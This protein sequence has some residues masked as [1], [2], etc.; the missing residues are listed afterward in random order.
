MKVIMQILLSMKSAIKN[1]NFYNE[2]K[3]SKKIVFLGDMLELGKKSK[4]FH[5]KCYLK[6]LIEV[7]LI[8]FLFM[9]NI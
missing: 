7:I 8:K 4:K 6:K 5:R 1:M 3:N 2:K 9:E